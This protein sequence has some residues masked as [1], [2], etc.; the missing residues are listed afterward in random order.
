MLLCYVCDY[1]QAYG[2]YM[3]FQ[4]AIKIKFVMGNNITI[5]FYKQVVI[6]PQ[7]P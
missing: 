7:M 5:A 3:A 6:I 1:S 4:V 2:F